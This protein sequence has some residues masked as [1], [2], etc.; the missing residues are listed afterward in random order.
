MVYRQG[1]TKISA[2]LTPRK[3]RPI[4]KSDIVQEGC[5]KETSMLK[6]DGLKKHTRYIKDFTGYIRK[7]RFIY[8]E[9]PDG[10]FK[11]KFLVDYATGTLYN[12]STLRPIFSQQLEI[13]E[14]P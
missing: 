12:A 6:M 5:I 9:L 8:L 3:K 10:K 1:D 2:N 13:V 11:G 4:N 7:G 14:Q